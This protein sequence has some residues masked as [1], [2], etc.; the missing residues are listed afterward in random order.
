MERRFV[1]ALMPNDEE[2]FIDSITES[3][4]RSRL[5]WIKEYQFGRNYDEAIYYLLHGE[6]EEKPQYCVCGK[7]LGHKEPCPPDGKREPDPWDAWFNTHPDPSDFGLTLP[8]GFWNT[9][10]EWLRSCPC[11]SGK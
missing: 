8:N 2:G 3:E 6:P 7:P 11:R 10:M 4:L 9:V 5:I 1:I